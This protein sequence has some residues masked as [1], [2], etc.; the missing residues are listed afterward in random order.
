MEEFKK[1]EIV[2]YKNY[3]EEPDW[4]FG[5]Y[6]KYEKDDKDGRHYI[7]NPYFTEFNDNTCS[8]DKYEL[9]FRYI[10][11][12][13]NINFGNGVIWGEKEEHAD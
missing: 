12:L 7:V 13:P 10:K 2:L 3:M 11:K 5:I 8:I 9:R 6:L 1:G 4:Q